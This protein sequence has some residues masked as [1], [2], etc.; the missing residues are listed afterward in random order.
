MHDLKYN[1]HFCVLKINL[2]KVHGHDFYGLTPISGTLPWSFA[3]CS[4][5]KVIRVFEAPL[6]FHQYL[7]ENGLSTDP[8]SIDRSVPYGATIKALALTNTAVYKEQD[9]EAAEVEEEYT[10][11]PDFA[12]RADPHVAKGKSTK[13]DCFHFL[14]IPGAPL[15]EHLS[16]NTLWPET[17][18]LY[19]HG[20][21]V[22]CV[23]CSSCGQ[24]LASACKAQRQDVAKIFIWDTGSWTVKQQ[25]NGHT[26][27]V[28]RLQFSPSGRHGLILRALR[29][30]LF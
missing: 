19:G 18:K 14:L 21:V 29:M 9:S 1:L 6:T 12:P 13:Q 30:M 3:S 28:T 20:D 11:G 17:Q 24:Y 4:E 2:L 23:D 10:S 8:L 26:L 5:E 27:T 22:F 25:L 15:E 16:Q 7:H